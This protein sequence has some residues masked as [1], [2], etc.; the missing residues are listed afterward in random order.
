MDERFEA[1]TEG[2]VSSRMDC[3]FAPTARII[4]ILGAISRY[5]LSSPEFILT[6]ETGHYWYPIQKYTNSYPPKE[7]IQKGKKEI[8]AAHYSMCHILF[9]VTPN[10]N[11]IVFALRGIASFPPLPASA[12][13]ETA[14]F[15]AVS[16]VIGTLQV[17]RALG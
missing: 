8:K 17:H 7:T 14:C 6:L 9:N 10:Y 12:T 11:Q 13:E 1:A 4:R 3:S 15:R 16:L 2:S 5:L